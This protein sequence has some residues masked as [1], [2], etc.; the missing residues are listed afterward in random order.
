MAAYFYMYV[1]IYIFLNIYLPINNIY[2]QII[3]QISIS[4]YILF[5]NIYIF[6]YLCLYIKVQKSL[7]DKCTFLDIRYQMFLTWKKTEIS[8][9]K[10][11]TLKNQTFDS[12]LR[13]R[14]DS[15]SKRIKEV[16]LLSFFFCFILSSRTFLHPAFIR[17]LLFLT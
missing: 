14:S 10:I 6:M 7:P 16:S 13:S 2:K 3:K 15:C 11:Q 4:K 8:S 9:Q 1:H 12:V 5:I 17:A